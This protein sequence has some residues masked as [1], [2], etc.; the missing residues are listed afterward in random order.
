M[1]KITCVFVNKKD[2][3]FSGKLYC[4][5]DYHFLFTTK[6]K[7]FIIKMIHGHKNILAR[8][9]VLDDGRYVLLKEYS[10]Y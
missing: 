2:N 3:N 10:N 7:L 6:L 8:I 5:R 1:Y 4:E 9:F